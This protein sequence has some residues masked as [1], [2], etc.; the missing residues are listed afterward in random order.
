MS[1]NNP[2]QQPDN[3]NVNPPL[4]PEDILNQN[5]NALFGIQDEPPQNQEE[6]IVD[7]HPTETEE[8][9]D[10]FEEPPDAENA[11]E[12]QD[13]N[14]EEV[15]NHPL[16]SISN[17]LVDSLNA[18]NDD[19]QNQS[20][21]PKSKNQIVVCA[22]TTIDGNGT[23]I[24]DN[25]DEG[26]EVDQLNN[27]TQEFSDYNN[28]QD[29]GELEPRLPP[30]PNLVTYENESDELQTSSPSVTQKSPRSNRN[31]TEG[32]ELPNVTVQKLSQGPKTARPVIPRTMKTAPEP[33]PE[34]EALVKK[35]LNGENISGLEEETY[36]EIIYYLGQ[37][38][39]NF[40]VTKRY[41]DGK[42]IND[43]IRRC[44]NCKMEVQ[45]AKIK[46]VATEEYQ[47]ALKNYQEECDRYDQ[48]TNKMLKELEDTHKVKREELTESHKEQ[49]L[50]HQKHWTAP[51]KYRLYNRASP[52][53]AVMHRTH[54]FLLMQCR[55]DEAEALDQEIQVKLKYE[56]A[57]NAKNYQRAYEESLSLLTQ[58]QR[59]EQEDLENRLAIEIAS[60]T[61]KRSRGRKYLDNKAKRVNL[62]GEAANDP[63]KLWNLMQMQRLEEAT[64]ANK[65]GLLLPSSKM[66][67]RDFKDQA[68]KFLTLPPLNLRSPTQSSPP[69]TAKR[70]RR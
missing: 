59:D 31:Q 60:L 26:N 58:K 70:T 36:D 5:S 21:T 61:Q 11:A 55:F 50:D 2:E 12:N 20:E 23:L 8:N 10:S 18:T 22:P 43:A 63:D 67:R 66:K 54:Q 44:E 41:K 3:E 6:E 69:A 34:I 28:D 39:K 57:T 64:N 29:P 49:L 51:S 15:N 40:A 9:N 13:T 37:S 17:I 27:G 30:I 4:K 48:E 53:I 65:S 24:S 47:E 42:K 19:T 68:V 52:D 38:R 46:K 33:S 32:F 7:E 35:A 1:D 25:P 14:T 62:K 45:K 16:D 56:E